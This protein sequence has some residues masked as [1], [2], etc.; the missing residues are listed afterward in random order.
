MGHPNFPRGASPELVSKAVIPAAG[1]GTRLLSVTKEQ[2]KEMLPVFARESK[3][4]LRLKPIVQLAFES[5]HHVGFHEFCFILGRG[6]RAIEDHFT[7]GHSYVSKLN[8]RGSL[9][10]AVELEAFYRIVVGRHLSGLISPNRKVSE[11]LSLK[12][13]RSSEAK[14]F[15]WMLGTTISSQTMIST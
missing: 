4:G 12:Q 1:L 7:P 2:P 5:L 9:S 3:G 13:G 10:S 8:S 6:K 11:M 14:H 15:L